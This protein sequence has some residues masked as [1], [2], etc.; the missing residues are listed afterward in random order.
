M[1]GPYV[2]NYSDHDDYQLPYSR[3]CSFAGSASGLHRKP[4]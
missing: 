4:W 1:Q 3:S 2:H